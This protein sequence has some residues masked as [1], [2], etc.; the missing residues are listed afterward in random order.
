MLNQQRLW[1]CPSRDAV[2]WIL[3]TQ[4]LKI[5]TLPRVTST[6]SVSNVLVSPGC[7]SSE[8]PAHLSK[9]SSEPPLMGFPPSL[10]SEL[11]D[12]VLFVLYWRSGLKC[13]PGKNVLG[14]PDVLPGPA[15]S[16]SWAGFSCS[17]FL[18]CFHPPHPPS[19]YC[20]GFP[21]HDNYC[22]K[23]QKKSQCYKLLFI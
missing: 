15:L 22:L 1:P 11:S 17:C 9:V 21:Y 23:Q 5:S 16:C 2:S 8:L 20:L 6:P 3:E 12:T 13:N 10:P 14:A 7:S 4:R 18:S 19:L